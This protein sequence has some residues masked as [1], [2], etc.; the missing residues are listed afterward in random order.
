MLGL[1]SGI[2]ARIFSNSY[3]NVL[4]KN[5][6]NNG[7]ASSVVNFYTYFGL[8]IIGFLVCPVPVFTVG[9]LKY[10]IVMGLLG[11]LGIILSLR[12][13]GRAHV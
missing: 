13:I 2:C 3:L 11:A 1:I 6:T 7:E 8:T 4:Q 10:V 9:I 5:L 12:Q